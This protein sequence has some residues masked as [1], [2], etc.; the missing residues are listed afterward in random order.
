MDLAEFEAR[1]RE[2]EL[3]SPHVPKGVLVL[4][5]HGGLIGDANV[6]WLAA[7]APGGKTAVL[8]EVQVQ[9]YTLMKMLRAPIPE[10]DLIRDGV[11]RIKDKRVSGDVVTE[12]IQDATAFS[13]PIIGR[14]PTMI[15]DGR[16]YAVSIYSGGTSAE[17]KWPESGPPEWRPLH[18][19][20]RA[21]RRRL[22]QMV[23]PGEQLYEYDS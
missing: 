6:S 11:V 4:R 17:F 15:L 20:A 10:A 23:N 8:R 9:R 21:M 18:E 1:L 19:W 16:S 13:I 2:P 14:R 5:L 7:Q 3:W 12:L 22:H